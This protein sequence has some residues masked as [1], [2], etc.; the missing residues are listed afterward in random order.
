MND[1]I[2]QGKI[3]YWGTSE[4]SAQ[5][6]TEAHAVARREH[7]IPPTME[8]PQ[9]NMFHRYRFEIEYK[10]VFEE[11]GY[12][13]TI[14]SPLASGVLS[15]KYNSGFPSDT[16][17][18][19][20]G[21][22]WL[23]ERVLTNENINKT[24]ALQTIA[25]DLGISLPQLAIAWCLKNKNVSTVILGGSK[26]TQLKE[27]FAALELQPKLTEDVLASIEQLLGNKPIAPGF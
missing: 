7:L 11:L 4:W 26:T 17:L 12:G 8:Q 3:L 18:G 2:R 9:Y 5:E 25:G 23:K 13:S 6:I 24:K 22:E 14:W 16:R 10:R 1:L 21:L 27:N 20:E 15:G 19:I